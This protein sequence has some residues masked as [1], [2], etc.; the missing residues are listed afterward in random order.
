[1]SRLRLYKSTFS[2]GEVTPQLLG[3][4]DLRAYENG[5]LRLR[6]VFIHPTGGLSRR[7]GLRYVDSAWGPGRLVGF[8]FSTEQTYL[9]LFTKRAV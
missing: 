4:S 3:R 5:A 7:S 2:S 1:M 9:L 6:N 8:E